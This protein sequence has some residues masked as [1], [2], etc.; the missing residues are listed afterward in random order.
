MELKEDYHT[1]TAGFTSCQERAQTGIMP[2]TLAAHQQQF[3]HA[4]QHDHTANITA[5]FMT[6]VQATQSGQVH[7]PQDV[8]EVIGAYQ[9]INPWLIHSEEKRAQLS[10][11]NCFNIMQTKL[12]MCPR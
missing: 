6:V 12:K 4:D 2:T 1:Y 9:K 7:I 5:Y 8:A 10:Y 3:C 11:I